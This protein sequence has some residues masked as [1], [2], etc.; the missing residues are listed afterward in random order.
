[1]ALCLA[2]VTLAV[3]WR[4]TS[5]DFVNYDDGDYVTNN[6]NVQKGLTAESLQWA[7]TFNYEGLRFP[8]TWISHIVDWQIYGNNAWGHHLTNV[9]LHTANTVLLF[10][11]LR[12]MTG[13]LWRSA[14]VAALFAVHPLHVETVA[15]V[16]ERK[17]L[18]S[19]AF[20]LL[21]L[22]TYAHYA[23]FKVLG[24]R[25]RASS[26]Y[27]LA[28]LFFACGLMSKPML[29]T[30]PA[31]LL[32]LDYWPLN[33]WNQAQTEQG[34][35]A[36]K[37]RRRLILEKI[38][39]FLLAGIYGV[40]TF[41]AAPD[42]ALSAGQRIGNALVS[43]P[44]Y[45]GKTLWPA[46]LA[47]PYPHPWNW[48]AWET[49]LAAVFLMAATGLAVRQPRQRAYLT[50]GW[51][52]FLGTLA[53]TLGLV[54]MSGLYSIADRYTYVPL[55]GIFIMVAW[56]AG[57]VSSQSNFWKGAAS[58]LAALLLCLCAWRTHDQILLW[59]DSGTLFSHTLKVTENNF[60]AHTNLGFHL[61][62]N[63]RLD[64]AIKHYVEAV[65]ICPQYSTAVNNLFNAQA[66]RNRPKQ[67]NPPTK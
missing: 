49:L 65:R 16:S 42:G 54:R 41:C 40:A 8:L 36:S 39:F 4:A 27:A 2:V 34:E 62:N 3:F 19:T 48:S 46:Q 28:L 64:E 25:N 44:R 67:H 51:L 56:T 58:A 57:E 18:L 61:E 59:H 7:L 35:H 30:L 13:S 23:R 10:L 6:S 37:H 63:G 66:A 14:F 26:H 55:I 43:Y 11:L 12:F 31:V 21:S 22:W 47:I 53:P 29:V 32:L 15:W 50:V 9:L 5:C 1:M 60:V 17:G 24:W 45:L 20:W 52:W 33:R 38:P